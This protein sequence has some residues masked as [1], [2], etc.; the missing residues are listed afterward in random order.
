MKK[1]LA[2]ALALCLSAYGCAGRTPNPVSAYQY[3]DDKK[4]CNALR[5]EIANTESDIQRKLPDA[6]KT[7]KNVALGVTGFFLIVPLFFMDFS[8]ADQVEVEA[9]RRRYNSLVILSAEKSCGFEFKPIPPFTEPP[10][11]TPEPQKPSEQT[12]A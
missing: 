6:D 7:G 5:A 3:G 11:V 1:A 2:I 4:S 12:G 10:E 9:L 8:Q